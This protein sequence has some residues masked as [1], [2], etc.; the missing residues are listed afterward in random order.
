MLLSN[1]GEFLP[2]RTKAK[3]TDDGAGTLQLRL[4]QSNGRDDADHLCTENQ[5]QQN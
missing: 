4:V 5:Q 1:V 3:D 2:Q